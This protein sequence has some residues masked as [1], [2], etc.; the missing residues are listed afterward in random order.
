MFELLKSRF[1]DFLD[2]QGKRTSLLP[3]EYR[4]QVVLYLKAD[5]G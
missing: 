4:D 1:S 2:R 3:E 5:L